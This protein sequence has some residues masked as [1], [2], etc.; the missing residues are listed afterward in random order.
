[1]GEGT[2][3][4]S[5]GVRL[6]LIVVVLALKKLDLLL[7]PN[8]SS[9]GLSKSSSF[10]SGVM[11]VVSVVV[12]VAMVVVVVATVAGKLG[13]AVAWIGFDRDRIF[14][15]PKE[16]G[17][18]IFLCWNIISLVPQSTVSACRHSPVLRSRA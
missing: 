7:D 16:E 6:V 11:V 12:V 14:P 15:K 8:R 13:L 4:S 1:M 5:V 10:N 2:T 9:F 3:I 18:L 17:T